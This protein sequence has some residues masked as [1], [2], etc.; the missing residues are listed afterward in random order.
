[1]RLLPRLALTAA[2]A[3]LP[4]AAGADVDQATL[5]AISTP[6]EVQ[7]SIGTLR[8]IDGAPLPE[9]A[10]TV[11]DY[12]D[13]ARGVDAFLKGMPAASLH[14]L[15]EGAHSIGAV[16]AHQVVIFD[17]LMDAKS[18]FLT[19]NSSTMY[20]MPD[21]DLERD[22]PTV[23]EVP[24]GAL[25]AFNDA[26]FRYLGDAGPFGP[27]KGEGGKYLVLPPG[28]EGQVPEGYFV[29][30]SPSF[31]V[32]I[33]MRMSIKDG[34]EAARRVVAD[35]LKVYPLAMADSPPALELISGSGQAFNTIHA[36]NFRFFEELDAVIQKEPL[37]FI[38]AETR[39]LFASIG[40]AK[41]K[42]FAPNQRMRAIL[43]D[44]V[45]IGNAAA[46]SIV[47]YPRVDMTLDG[48]KIFDDRRWI[49][50]F[51]NRD[52]FFN[53]EDDHTMNTDARVMF[54][55]PYTAVTPA[56]AKP[57]IG[58]GSDYGIAYVDASGQPFDGTKTYKV[59]LPA[60][61]P[62]KDF[63]SLTVYD[64]QTRS[65]LQTER[66]PPAL[67]SIQNQ[68]KANADGSVDIYF[69]PE[70]PSGQEN[71][72]IQTI[73]GKSFFVAL[74]MYGPLEA[75]HEKTWKPGDIELVE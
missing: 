16:A 21:L 67:D 68:P 73:P 47:W 31:R 51:L 15:I 1:M 70:P 8:F 48:I 69:A 17:R 9:T 38:N 13:R 2:L 52:V 43:E 45:A 60:N 40:I 12:L 4:L 39:G 23:V 14:M 18:L 10:A 19:P 6:N 49:M 65:M 57:R 5:D 33:F 64:S 61:P 7:T 54:H 37:D 26:Y 63:W 62:I 11:Y 55:Y 34:L 44:A 72:W 36:N 75:W 42:P 29:V 53:G 59:N 71:N 35:K 22:G 24:P 74:R 32:W 25:G 56:M 3:T 58:I 28:F 46:R 20:V 66:Q 27:D 30:R 50:A 41:G